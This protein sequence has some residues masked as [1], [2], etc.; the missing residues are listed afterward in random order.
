MRNGIER[1]SDREALIQPV[2]DLADRVSVIFF[3][4][5]HRTNLGLNVFRQ[6]IEWLQDGIAR[7]S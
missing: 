2:I 4:R 6:L 3:Q 5:N 1:Q 7:S